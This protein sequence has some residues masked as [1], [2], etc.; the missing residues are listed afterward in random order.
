MRET[1][2]VREGTSVVFWEAGRHSQKSER[3]KERGK[4][5]EHVSELRGNR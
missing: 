4:K 1:E 5:D 2:R 3:E